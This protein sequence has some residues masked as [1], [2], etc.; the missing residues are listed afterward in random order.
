MSIIS[1]KL[2]SALLGLVL[3]SGSAWAGPTTIKGEVKGPDGRPVKG[4]EVMIERNGAKG[5]SNSMKTDSQGRYVFTYLDPGTYN[6][7]ASAN[8]LAATG[9]ENVMPKPDSAISVNFM[10]KK[11]TGTVPATAQVK[12]KA[13]HMV[14]MPPETGSNLGGRWVEVDEAGLSVNNVQRHSG[15]SI[16]AMQGGHGGASA[17]NGV[18]G[19]HSV[20]GSGPE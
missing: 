11:Q 13:K 16:L 18:D 19:I 2:G 10:L 4:A 12:K 14:W 5:P 17:N 20:Y 6:V 8:G 9:A 3:L 15:K 1:R 7:Q